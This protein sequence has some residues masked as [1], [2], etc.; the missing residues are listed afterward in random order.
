MTLRRSRF[1]STIIAATLAATGSFVAAGSAHAAEIPAGADIADGLAVHVTPNG[2]DFLESQVQHL[3]PPTVAVANQGGDLFSCLF[4]TCEWR[5]QNTV[6]TL[7]VGKVSLTPLEGRL[8]LHLE[9]WVSANA[10]VETNGCLFN[11]GCSVVLD[12]SLVVADTTIE[13]QLVP[14]GTGRFDVDAETEAFDI[15]LG[16]GD[17][18]INDCLLGDFLEFFVELFLGTI[19]DVVVDVL[20][21][22]V[23]PLIEPA[24]EDAFNSLNIAGSFDV[25]GVPIDY[26]FYPTRLE[27]HPGTIGLVMGGHFVT[28]EVAPCADPDRGSV[29]TVGALPDYTQVP[30]DTD[31]AGSIA[32]DILNQLLFSAWRGGLL[33]QTL[34]EMG[35]EPLSSDLLALVGG[36][37]S[38]IMTDG[39]RLAVRI[40]TPEPPVATLGGPNGETAVVSL[41]NLELDVFA[42]V[43]DRLVR[44]FGLTL[45][46]TAGVTLEMTPDGLLVPTLN[47]DPAAA[48]AQVAYNELAPDVNETLLTLLPTILE[49][50]LPQLT[51]AIPPIALPDLGGI[52]LESAAFTPDGPAG[53][54]LTAYASLGG[55]VSAGGC[56]AIP[57]GGCGVDA[58]GLGCS[59]QGGR[60]VR[61]NAAT[62][63]ASP[64]ML[65][66]GIGSLLVRRRKE[67]REE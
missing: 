18:D 41:A 65:L 39:G 46:P 12:P 3:I 16:L 63:L 50:F 58:G 36:S 59:I 31:I 30:G 67:A 29:L 13:M 26:D 2:I 14:D 21:D 27:L 45:S 44:V 5:L 43:R 34:D 54:Y 22:Q 24:I 33:C 35:G 42:D 23:Q 38:T 25:A 7:D 48:D 9:L 20:V 8:Q 4:D 53:D 37:L 60:R 10:R 51:E 1:R 49:Q 64:A 17:P 40:T 57:G 62:V 15:Q 47:F 52:V 66:V 55:Q 11:N 32:D 61:G 56:S 6:V 28:N 19:E